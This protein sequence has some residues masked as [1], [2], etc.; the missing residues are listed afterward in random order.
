ME[1]FYNYMIDSLLEKYSIH[2]IHNFVFVN[3]FYFYDATFFLIPSLRKV[4]GFFWR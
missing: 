3:V 1:H 2:F 4:G